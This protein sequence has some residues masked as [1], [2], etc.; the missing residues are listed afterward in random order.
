MNMAKNAGSVQTTPLTPNS[1]C[2][3][4]GSGDTN[5]STTVQFYSPPDGIAWWTGSVSSGSL[6]AVL[7]GDI[8]DS[9][10]TYRKGLT[11]A[12]VPAGI[13]AYN[14][15]LTGDI[16]DNGTIYTFQAHL[17]YMSTSA[18]SADVLVQPAKGKGLPHCS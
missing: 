11:L 3:A 4:S 5:N 9:Q 15:I 7:A 16:V 12:Y 6:S 17:V 14:V 2:A 8:G 10:V 1:N 18:T 13:G